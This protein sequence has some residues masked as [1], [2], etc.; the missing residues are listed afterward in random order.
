MTQVNHNSITGIGTGN[1]DPKVFTADNFADNAVNVN[2][3]AS[4]TKGC[5]KKITHFNDNT[6]NISDSN[7]SSNVI[8][9]FNFTRS[10]SSNAI[11]A[12]GFV[13][14]GGSSSSSLVGSYVEIDSTG[15]KH[16]M[17]NFRSPTN[18]T[19][20]QFGIF[21]IQGAWTAGTLG[22]GTSHTFK[23]GK[24]TRNGNNEQM[25]GSANPFQQSGRHRSNTTQITLFETDQLNFFT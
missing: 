3:F 19:D 12:I 24:H 7:N 5:I 8:I 1:Y 25:G 2:K 23:I 20:G 4:N 18:G 6:V 14:F 16:D 9:T 15:R 17:T 10:S 11:V 13:P 22:S 21:Q